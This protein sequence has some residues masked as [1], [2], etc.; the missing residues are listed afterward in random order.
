MYVMDELLWLRTVAQSWESGWKCRRQGVST[1]QERWFRAGA[2][3][4]GGEGRLAEVTGVTACPVCASTSRADVDK[5]T[6]L[7]CVAT[8]GL[9]RHL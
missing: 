7:P 4:G 8:E 9:R 3:D 1:A 6:A 2:P 5:G